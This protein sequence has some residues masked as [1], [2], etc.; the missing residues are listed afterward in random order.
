MKPIIDQYIQQ[1]KDYKQ[2]IYKKLYV[3]I[4]IFFIP[5]IPTLIY[6]NVSPFI[7]ILFWV[8]LSIMIIFLLILLGF[9]L[10][11][12]ERPMYEFLY[13][14][15]IDDAFKDDFTHYEYE[16]FPKQSPFYERGQ[17]MNQTNSEVIKYRLTFY[18]TNN[19]IDLFSLYN[20]GL[21]SKKMKPIFNGIY[22]VF[23]NINLGDFACLSNEEITQISSLADP[24]NNMIS[25]HKII[26]EEMHSDVFIRSLKNE[27]HIAINKN[28][29]HLKP[30]QI[31]EKELLDLSKNIWDLV[32]YG[33]KLYREIETLNH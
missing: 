6:Y 13:K 5:F 24:P 2:S 20:Y 22:Y 15:V 29:D 3:L 9:M 31:S 23:H 33:R 30:N 25:L 4:G 10:F 27:V 18:Y 11:T 32:K 21:N 12:T 1:Y 7:R 8:F 19:R 28:Y 17:L 14:D 16:A 26:H